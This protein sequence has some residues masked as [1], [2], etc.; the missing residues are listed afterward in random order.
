MKWELFI[1]RLFQEAQSYLAVRGDMLH[2][3]VAH[4]YAL[5]LMR[6]EGGDRKIVE[7]A[8][9][10]H[11]VGWSSLEPSQIKVAY[12]V[13]A[14]SQEA[15]RLNR[16]HES[17]GASIAKQILSSLDYAPPLIEEIA[18]I[19]SKH[20]SGLEAGSLEEALVKDSDKLWRTSEI[21]FRME[22]E[23]QG[24][25][26]KDYY[27]FL[28]AHYRGWLFTPSALVLAGKELEKRGKEIDVL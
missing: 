28:Q 25:E 15:K 21:G 7:P 4:Q 27:D 5:I 6:H 17:D 10:L 2:A 20:D 13:K 18:S 24:L 14:R 3:Q 23:R 19:I 16:I 22:I 26:A 8:V 9:I 11:D 1:E 12:G